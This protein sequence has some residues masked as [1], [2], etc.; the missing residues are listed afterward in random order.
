M[1]VFNGQMPFF[2]GNLHMHTTRSDGA[3][4]PEAATALYRANGYDFIALTDHDVVGQDTHMEDGMLILSGIELA[5]E[6][7]AEEMHIVGIG[8]PKEA[9]T[10]LEPLYGPQAAIDTIR[11]SGGRAILAH[12]AWSLLTPATVSGLRGISAAEIYNA[13]STAPRNCL[14]ADASI[15]LDCAAAHGCVLPLVAVDDAHFYEGE[16]CNS[17]IMAQAPTLSQADL[18]GAIDQG[19]F[20][21]S[22]GPEIKRLSVEENQIRLECSP[23]SSIIFYSNLSWVTG[24]CRTGR[25]L[26]ESVYDLDA[27]EGE[28]YVRCQI[29][30]ENGKSAWTNPIILNHD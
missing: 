4:T 10:R 16:H 27:Q 24:R 13:M 20:Y 18:L 28:T 29:V 8:L 1:E 23:A 6:L 3:L 22:Q 26:T 9:E 14:R 5:F 7:P 12:P 19:R 2:K 30:D 25:N 21:A 15:T 17:Y 11:R